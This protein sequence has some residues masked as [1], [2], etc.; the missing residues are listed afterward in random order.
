MPQNYGTGAAAEA[1]EP[2]SARM[3]PRARVGTARRTD[4]LFKRRKPLRPCLQGTQQLWNLSILRLSLSSVFTEPCLR[5]AYI[6]LR[7]QSKLSQA[8]RRAGTPRGLLLYYP[9]QKNAILWRKNFPHGCVL[10]PRNKF[11]FRLFKFSLT[12]LRKYYKV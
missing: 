8:R 12:F 9:A 10:A 2:L 1:P 3:T 7:P 11:H 4:R 5:Y 6:A